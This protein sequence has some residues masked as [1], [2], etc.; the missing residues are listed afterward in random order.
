MKAWKVALSHEESA[1]IVDV[2]EKV[3]GKKRKA[4]SR[5]LR[6]LVLSRAIIL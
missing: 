1:D 3:A 2:P 5:V 6:Q 4:V